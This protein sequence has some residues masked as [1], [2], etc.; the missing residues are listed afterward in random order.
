MC[1]VLAFKELIIAEVGT[2]SDRYRK[3]IDLYT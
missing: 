3:I 1:L 2:G